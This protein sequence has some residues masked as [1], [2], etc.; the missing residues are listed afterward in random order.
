LKAKNAETAKAFA[1][2]INDEIA[3]QPWDTAIKTEIQEAI[4]N[5]VPEKSV[6]AKLSVIQQNP[7]HLVQLAMLLN[8]YDKEKGFN[9]QE[10]G[11][12]DTKVIK[13]AKDNISK[14]FS[15]NPSTSNQTIRPREKDIDWS[16]F[17][18]T[19]F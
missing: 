8:K 18:I 7:A 1:K 12:V 16:K 5:K 14:L 13:E 17:S 9:L 10:I 2:N 19:P 11:N 3:K 6:N 15:R 4:Y